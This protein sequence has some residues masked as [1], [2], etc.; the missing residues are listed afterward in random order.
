MTL[1]IDANGDLVRQRAVALPW[2]T[3][4][5][6]LAELT[7]A[8]AMAAVAAWDVRDL[9]GIPS[10]I[11]RAMQSKNRRIRKK[12]RKRARPYLA[13]RALALTASMSQ[14]VSAILSQPLLDFVRP[15]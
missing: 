10:N 13:M 12:G 7:I 6:Q 14:Q 3:R 4:S 8:G 15:P 5:Q 9:T 11:R 1:L 2:V